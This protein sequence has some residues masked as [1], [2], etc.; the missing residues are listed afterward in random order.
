[1][2]GMQLLVQTKWGKP[3]MRKRGLVVGWWI[4]AACKEL[5]KHLERDFAAQLVQTSGRLQNEEIYST[6]FV[7]TQAS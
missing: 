3:W 4:A 1:M 7:M 5:L 2:N 6:N